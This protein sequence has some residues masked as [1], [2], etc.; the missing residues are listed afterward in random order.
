M[1]HK[2]L[3][4]WS[5]RRPVYVALRLRSQTSGHS[6]VTP[7]QCEGGSHVTFLHVTDNPE[8][9]HELEMDDWQFFFGKD[10]DPA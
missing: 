5:R 10:V 8:N 7:Q 4:V 2:A 9:A 6:P 3:Q 1:T